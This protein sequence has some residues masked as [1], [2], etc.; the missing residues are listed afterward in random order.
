MLRMAHARRR[1]QHHIISRPRRGMH[2]PRRPACDAACWAAA[3]PNAAAARVPRPAELGACEQRHRPAAK[4]R[5]LTMATQQQRP[6][7][8]ISRRSQQGAA[9]DEI[10]RLRGTFCPPPA[11]APTPA[12]TRM[13]GRSTAVRPLAQARCGSAHN[14]ELPLI[15]V[16]A[17]DIRRRLS[18]P[19]QPRAWPTAA[20]HR[21]IVVEAGYSA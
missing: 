12:P 8:V 3:P 2:R 7:G 10:A 11:G 19:H 5:C 14:D 15:F 4:Q 9:C 6:V 13:P 21:R 1:R 17:L 16:A 20:L 18:L